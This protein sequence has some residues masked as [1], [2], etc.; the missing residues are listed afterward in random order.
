MVFSFRLYSPG[1]G[2]TTPTICRRR[3]SAL[4]VLTDA[5]LGLPAEDDPPRSS[6]R[7]DEMSARVGIGHAVSYCEIV[8]RE[9]RMADGQYRPSTRESRCRNQNILRA[10]ARR[11]GACQW[12]TDNVT[13][14][15][16]CRRR[17]DLKLRLLATAMVLSA[18]V[19]VFEASMGLKYRRISPAECCRAAGLAWIASRL[20]STPWPKRLMNY[21]SGNHLWRR[22]RQFETC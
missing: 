6:M 18:I 2:A 11:H 14:F 7:R 13:S 3:P 10:A 5:S 17:G 22:S 9:A 20:Q 21:G 8:D 19:Q 12:R 4:S 1:V 15:V 16:L